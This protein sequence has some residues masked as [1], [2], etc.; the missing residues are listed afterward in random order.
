MVEYHG[1]S[2]KSNLNMNVMWVGMVY[3]KNKINR[4]VKP[5]NV[6]KIDNVQK[7]EGAD[8][9]TEMDTLTHYNETGN[10]AILEMWTGLTADDKHVIRKMI[11]CLVQMNDIDGL[12]KM[13][14]H[15]YERHKAADVS[16][17][18]I[19][20]FQ[21]MAQEAT[22]KWLFRWYEQDP[23]AILK[24]DTDDLVGVNTVRDNIAQF[25]VNLDTDPAIS[26]SVTPSGLE[27][28]L[29]RMV[30]G[31]IDEKT[32]EREIQTILNGMNLETLATWSGI[33]KNEGFKSLNRYKSMGDDSALPRARLIGILVEKMNEKLTVPDVTGLSAEELSVVARYA[34]GGF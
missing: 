14:S 2:E 24:H 30:N 4:L 16:E 23:F 22:K 5:F 13:M 9:P 1:V 7:F 29:Q 32:Y 26:Y 15:A 19:G 3:D 21:R 34:E 18:S 8:V 17:D 27:D 12:N 25:T 31:E 10:D 28:I 33:V 11:V 20:L 6:E